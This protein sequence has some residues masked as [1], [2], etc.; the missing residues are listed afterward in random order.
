[1]RADRDT[2]AVV[3]CKHTGRVRRFMHLATRADIPTLHSHPGE[4]VMY[5]PGL[6]I[7]I[8][9]IQPRI[10]KLL[11]MVAPADDRY[12]VVAANGNVVSA[13]L[14]CPQCGDAVPGHTLVAH[15]T[16]DKG[17]TYVAGVFTAPPPVVV[18]PV[19]PVPL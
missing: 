2:T 14:A 16:A 13:I 10:S 9:F 6:H 15:A 3:Y 1:M 8:D 4:S 18:V 17:W 11:G 5:I 19:V 12:A 7:D